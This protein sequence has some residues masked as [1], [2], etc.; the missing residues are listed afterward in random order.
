STTTTP[1]SSVNPTE[2]AHFTTLA[3]SWWD[4][5]GSSRLLHLMN[6]LRHDFIRRCHSVSPPA[7]GQKLEYLDI[8]CGGGIFA[9]SAARLRNT[10]GVVGIDP[11]EM[12]VQVAEGH[13]RSDPGL[14]E[15]GRLRYLNTAIE[16]LASHL[17]AGKQF[18]I[19][20]VFEVV[21]H[22][23]Q[24][25]PFLKQALNFLRPGG[26]LIGSTIARTPMSWFTTKFVAE[27]VLGIV[28]KGTHDW[29]QYVNPQ[30]LREWARRE[31]E[32]DTSDGVGWRVM[33]VVYVPGVGWREVK[34]SEGFGNYFLG[35]RKR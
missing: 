4:P 32:L 2:T 1:Q 26:W 22:I 3:S 10:A 17:P 12:C 6:P 16:D 29:G 8:G 5:H 28:P 34:G 11:T 15:E 20:S 33:G 35:V 14:M 23:R 31:T 13:R 21:E 9:E 25:A 30:E 18:D 27:D 19:V 7:P 24:P